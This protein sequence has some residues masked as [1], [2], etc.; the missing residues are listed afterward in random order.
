MSNKSPKANQLQRNLNA[1]AKANNHKIFCKRL[2]KIPSL[3]QSGQIWKPKGG[4][5]VA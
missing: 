3:G 1:L 5:E 4:E 2:K